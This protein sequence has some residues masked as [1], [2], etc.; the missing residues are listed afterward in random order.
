MV[1]YEKIGKII[2]LLSY[3][4]FQYSAIIV[5][6]Y[7]LLPALSL[8][9]FFNLPDLGGAAMLASLF[10]NLNNFFRDYLV[11]SAFWTFSL[12]PIDVF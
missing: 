3:A 4:P 10:V 2:I 7:E 6:F 5:N 11:N 9:F 12:R 1:H 8:L